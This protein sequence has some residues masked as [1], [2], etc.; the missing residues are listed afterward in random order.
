MDTP[1]IGARYALAVDAALGEGEGSLAPG[2]VVQVVRIAPPGTPGVGRAGHD[3]VIAE[4]VYE[5]AGVDELGAA[6]RIS[7]VRYLALAAP[8]FAARF[9]PVD[10]VGGGS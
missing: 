4:H 7:H 2:A 10:D 9:T 5:T 1:E 8:V 3:T 6:V